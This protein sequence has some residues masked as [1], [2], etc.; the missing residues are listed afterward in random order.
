MAPALSPTPM[1]LNGSSF[2]A[3]SSLE[4]YDH[5][6]DYDEKDAPPALPPMNLGLGSPPGYHSDVDEDYTNLPP[7]VQMNRIPTGGAFD[8]GSDEGH[9][10]REMSHAGLGRGVTF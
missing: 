6:Q 2:G 7:A 3:T 4:D 8:A 1:A 9:A 10:G 5:T